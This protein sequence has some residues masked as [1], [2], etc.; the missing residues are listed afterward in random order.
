MIEAPETRIR[1]AIQARLKDAGLAGGRVYNGFDRELGPDEMPALVLWSGDTRLEDPTGSTGRTTPSR[2]Q[3]RVQEL[4]ISCVE[5]RTADDLDL[6]AAE[7]RAI[8]LGTRVEEVLTTGAPDLPEDI[9]LAE[10]QHIVLA[11][12]KKADIVAIHR[13][14]IFELTYQSLAGKPRETHF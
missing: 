2:I 10:I 1:K 7:D 6:S 12:P 8:E 11:D 13:V 5:A 3:R 9:R 4:A 14:L